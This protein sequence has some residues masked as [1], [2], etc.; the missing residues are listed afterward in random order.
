MILREVVALFG[1]AAVWPRVV[2]AEQPAAVIGFLNPASSAPYA[3]LVAVDDPAPT[4]ADAAVRAEPAEGDSLGACPFN[5]FGGP[6]REYNSPKSA[7]RSR[8]FH[9]CR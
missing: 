5:R 1:R 8:P 9:R 2:H 6:R 4:L 3:S 7:I